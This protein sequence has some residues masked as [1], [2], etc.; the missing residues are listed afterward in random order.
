MDIILRNKNGE[1]EFI[2][3]PVSFDVAVGIGDNAE[4]DFEL[5]V[6]ANAPRAEQGTIRVHRGYAIRR[7]DYAY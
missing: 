2:I 3:D 1:D 6:P 4:N 7:H 5:T